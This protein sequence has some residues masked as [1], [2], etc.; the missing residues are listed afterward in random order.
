MGRV[1]NPGIIRT[2]AH[3][4]YLASSADPSRAEQALRS[5][6]AETGDLALEEILARLDDPYPEI[7]EEAARALGRIGSPLAIDALLE[8]LQD[9]SS[10]LQVASARALGRIG[11]HRAVDALS[12][13]LRSSESEELQ[14]ACVQALGDIGGERAAEEVLAL[15]RRTISDRLRA[16][17]SDAAGRLG[18]FEAAMEILP[19]LI[20][21]KSSS[22]RRQYAIALGNLL[23]PPGDFYRYVSGSE[24]GMATRV[25]KLFTRLE[26]KLNSAS[27]RIAGKSGARAS[28]AEANRSAALVRFILE[29]LESGQELDA[30]RDIVS[31]SS[32]L[33]SELFGQEIDSPQLLELAFR[34]DPKLGAFVWLLSE[35]NLLLEE[36]KGS[37]FVAAI[38]GA[39]VQ[40]LL[41]LLVA[42]F[43]ASA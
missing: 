21:G 40:R 29:N 28:K 43:L 26:I 12:E 2:Y 10:S 14:E 9:G 15:Y 36:K 19:R 4:D 32:E 25:A 3:L 5:I 27:R 1:A 8:H 22:L 37:P 16:S 34:V 7:R 18:V 24:S 17:A 23:G 11:D 30:L 35:L 39:D 13:L 20:A 31:L 42:Y 41:V 6:E 33:M 38:D